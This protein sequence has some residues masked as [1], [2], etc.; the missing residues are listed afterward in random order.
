MPSKRAN[1]LLAAALGAAAVVTGVAFIFWPAAPI[2]G[3]CAAIYA[4][5]FLIDI[6]PSSS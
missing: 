4:A 6:S 2:V 1:A 3:G 5:L